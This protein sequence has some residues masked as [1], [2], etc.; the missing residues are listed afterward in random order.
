MSRHEDPRPTLAPRALPSQTLDLPRVVHLVV[1]EHRQLHLLLFVLDLLGGGV[2]LLL[3]LLA[4]PSETK[5]KVEGGL[6]LD[7][8]VGECASILKLL[9]GKDQPLLVGRNT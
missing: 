9:P 2:V 4:S 8:V 5:H 6:L 1:L 7:V 3:P